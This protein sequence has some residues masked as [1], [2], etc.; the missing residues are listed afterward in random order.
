MLSFYFSFKPNK[1][2]CVRGKEGDIKNSSHILQYT[3]IRPYIIILES[4]TH[5]F[6][7]LSYFIPVILLSHDEKQEI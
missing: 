4:G 1:T 5:A 2:I 3:R 6:I 7:S